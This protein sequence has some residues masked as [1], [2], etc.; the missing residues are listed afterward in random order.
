MVP[1]SPAGPPP[2]IIRL[3]RVEEL[4]QRRA[5]SFGDVAGAYQRARPSYPRAAVEWLLRPAPGRAVVDLAAGTGKLTGVLV[6]AG[7]DVDAVEP[8]PEMLAELRAAHP[9]VRALEGSA[10]RIP[11][12]DASRDAVLV[13]QAFHWFEA[14]PALQAIARVLR[15]G[16]I[17]GLLWNLRDDRVPWVAALTA[18]L[19]GAGDVLSASRRLGHEPLLDCP[20]FESLQRREFPN[21]ERFSRSRLLDWARSTSSVAVMEPSEREQLLESLER[22]C[23][24]HPALRG[25][26]E[27]EVPF[28]TVCVRAV[29]V[30]GR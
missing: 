23:D 27:F 15:P 5:R 4:L 30:P 21:L 9:K 8:L 16:G 25:R 10:E 19:G 29:R 24:T 28:V 1:K 18:A 17:L 3:W 6:R 22:L 11:V 13:A 12:A 7:C 20:S 2:R 14:H 26:D